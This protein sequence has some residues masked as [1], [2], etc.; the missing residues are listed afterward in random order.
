MRRR[1]V[2]A[3]LIIFASGC[4]S[5][6]ALRPTAKDRPLAVHVATAERSPRPV[7][8]EVLGTVR[9]ARSATIAP[10]VSGTIAE[11]RVG[12]GSPVRAGEI[13]VRLSAREIDA[14][15]QQSRSVLALAK[16]ERDRAARLRADDVISVAQY[17]AAISGFAVA[18]ASHAEAS[19]FAERTVLR[20]PFAGVITAKL[21]NVGDTAMPGQP[22]LTLEAPGALRFEARVPDTGGHQLTVGETLT[23][24]LD[25]L[26]LQGRVA[27]IQ[28]SSDDATRTRLIKVD[29]PPAASGQSGRFGRLLL[30]TGT[31]LDVSVPAAAVARHGQLET[32]FVVEEGTVRLRLVRTGRER[33]GRLEIASGLYADEKVAIAGALV[34]GQK[35]EAQP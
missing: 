28:P 25:E 15:L 13:L 6:P 33:D 22:L 21:T 5:D 32:V 2:V 26:D 29:L 20:A 9:A 7:V 31:S 12:L 35:V 17:D 4:G 27:E 14:R 16:L 24:R 11:V 3:A 18:Q 10:L 8:T 34:D 30:T 19:T 1:A 23:V